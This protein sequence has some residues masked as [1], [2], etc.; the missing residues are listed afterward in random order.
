MGYVGETGYLLYRLEGCR[1]SPS[2]VAILGFGQDG[3]DL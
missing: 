1:F 3:G 2:L